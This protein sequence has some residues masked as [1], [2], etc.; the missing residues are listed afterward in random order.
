MLDISLFLLQSFIGVSK[1][2]SFSTPKVLLVMC[3]ESIL[4]LVLTDKAERITDLYKLAVP[5]P[6]KEAGFLPVKAVV[7]TTDWE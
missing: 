7:S 3:N 2:G 1:N 5:D 6:K 4:H